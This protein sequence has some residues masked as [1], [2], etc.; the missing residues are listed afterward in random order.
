MG[1][2]T[3]TLDAVRRVLAT[4]PDNRV[5]LEARFDGNGDDMSVD[6]EVILVSK[7]DGRRHVVSVQV[8]D[9]YVGVN[10]SLYEAKPVGDFEVA[11]FVGMRQGAPRRRPSGDFEAELHIALDGSPDAFE[12]VAGPGVGTHPLAGL[13]I[14]QAAIAA[15]AYNADRPADEQVKLAL[16]ADGAVGDEDVV[17]FVRGDGTSL[18]VQVRTMAGGARVCDART[19]EAILEQDAGEA[20]S[21]L[22]ECIGLCLGNEE[23]TSPAP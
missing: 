17:T 1:H 2:V 14:R 21:R 4:Q 22:A 19:D 8:G 13:V 11:S 15:S 6:S 9:G 3:D 12:P 10:T 5:P 16:N 7:A 20:R 18:P 23:A